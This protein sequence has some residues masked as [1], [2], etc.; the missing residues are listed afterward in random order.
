MKARWWVSNSDGTIS[1]SLCFRGCRIRSGS[2]GKCGVRFND[3]VGMVAP[4]LGRFCAVAV[5]PIEKKPLLYWR[6]G[7]FIYSLGSLGC[8]M[9]CPFCQNHHIAF[10]SKD[11]YD[12]RLPTLAPSQLVRDIKEAGLSSVA[13]TYNEPTLQAEF[14][15]E[16]APLIHDAGCAVVLVTNAAMSRTAAGDLLSCLNTTDAANIDVKA[17]NPDT[18]RKLGGDLDTVRANVEAFIAAGVHVELTSLI[19]PGLNDSAE[20][21]ASMVDWIASM[22]DA[23]PLHV[24][25]YFPARSYHEPPTNINLMRSL[26]AIASSKLR[27]V[28]LGNIPH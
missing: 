23:I 20:E 3:G 28:H 9:D 11:L 1:C 16:A 13:F 27:R 10:P 12:A 19:V 5:D 15:C 24:T 6:P 14:I 21:F 26:A 7:S 22:S 2:F 25:R 17:F 18:Y 8:T 4:W